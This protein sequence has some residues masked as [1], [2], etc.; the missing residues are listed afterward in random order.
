MCSH[1]GSLRAP[2]P[3]VRIWIEVCTILLAGTGIYSQ[4]GSPR[5]PSPPH[6]QVP[7][8]PSARVSLAPRF[9]PG[10][11]LRYD[12]EFESSQ[13]MSR[14]GLVADPQG[15]SNSVVDWNATV[16]IE[17]LPANASAPAAAGGI[18]L[19]TTYEKSSANVKSDTFDPAADETRKQY[20][21]L[22]GK[23]I[24]FTLDPAGKVQSVLGLERVLE[25]EKAA[26]SAQEWM[27]QLSASAGAPAKGVKIGDAWSSEQ[28]AD[29]LPLTGLVWRTDSQYL[30]N[31][32][33]RTATSLGA[34]AP[35]QDSAAATSGSAEMCAVVFASLS[36]V[37]AKSGHDLTPPEIRQNG[38][39]T[40]G[41][42]TGSGQSLVYVS[43]R[44]GFVMSVTQSATE[45]MD[46]TVTTSR[47]AQLHYVGT[48]A[49]R[50]QVALTGD[51]RGG[52]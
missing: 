47:G 48:I 18:R 8:A 31:E 32:P 27:G 38:L 35:S 34:P 50:S 3:L 29:S 6:G 44:S 37:R 43:L 52:G 13:E 46:V 20:Q 2:R 40:A 39:R 7:S 25:G 51:G 28:A 23:V 41:E 42:C 1:L 12:L 10:Q 26:K 15:P 30:R 5:E 24:E 17:V 9:V 22:Q 21:G 45:Q 49:T 14:S 19:R 33:C 36:L 16:R 4:G 11:T